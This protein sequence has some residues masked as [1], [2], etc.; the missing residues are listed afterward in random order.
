MSHFLGNHG[1][2]WD[3]F[4]CSV[5]APESWKSIATA[6]AST[7]Q[8][9]CGQTCAWSLILRR[10]GTPPDVVYTFYNLSSEGS[11]RFGAVVVST[12]EH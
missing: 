5:A 3:T 4:F 6:A 1:I 11:K 9:A 12:I 10:D 2:T 8:R 7:R